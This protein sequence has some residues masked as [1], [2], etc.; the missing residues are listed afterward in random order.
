MHYIDQGNVG[1]N[2]HLMASPYIINNV[3][4]DLVLFERSHDD[5]I[6]WIKLSFSKLGNDK[7]VLLCGCYNVPS[8]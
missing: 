2:V 1:R 6:L 3:F 8:G 5:C 4:S 7:D